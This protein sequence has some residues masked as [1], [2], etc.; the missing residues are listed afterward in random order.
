[1][2]RAEQAPTSPASHPDGDPG[3]APGFRLLGRRLGRARG[4]VLLALLLALSGAASLLEDVSL[5]LWANLAA[6]CLAFL[7]AYG[8]LMRL[9]VAEPP[10]EP[11]SPG[12]WTPASEERTSAK[13]PGGL[14]FG[15]EGSGGLSRARRARPLDDPEDRQTADRRPA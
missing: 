6:L 14:S 12:A 9:S 13:A 4:F 1:M 7:L 8:A 5:P 11:S 2:R 15:A 3:Q 10:D